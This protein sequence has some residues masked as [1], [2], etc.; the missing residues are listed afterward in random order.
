MALEPWR[1][2]VDEVASGLAVGHSV[3]QANRSLLVQHLDTLMQ[4][5]QLPRE[6]HRRRRPGRE[7]GGLERLGQSHGGGGHAVVEGDDLVGRRVERRQDRGDRDLGPGRLRDR[8][9]EQH[10]LLGHARE[11]GCVGPVVV[12]QL[13]MVLAQRVGQDDDDPLGLGRLLGDESAAPDDR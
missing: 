10:A 4:V 9:A 1:Q 5:G 8:V 2:L 12:I 6:R 13:E 7:A 11:V 3:R